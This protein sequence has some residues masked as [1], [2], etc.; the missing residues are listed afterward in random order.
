MMK[1][2]G[3]DDDDDGD[4]DDAEKNYDNFFVVYPS[5][6]T[7]F[8]YEKIRQVHLYVPKKK[9]TGLDIGTW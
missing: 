8:M 3:I 4:D 9:G 1:I 6:P 5:N 7:N 2:D